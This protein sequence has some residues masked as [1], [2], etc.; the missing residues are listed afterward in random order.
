MAWITAI[1]GPAG[2]GKSTMFE[3]LIDTYK[4]YPNQ[5]FFARPQFPRSMSPGLGAWG[6]SYLDYMAIAAAIM[7]PENDYWVD[8][9]LISRTVYMAIQ[10]NN[11]QLFPDW[12]Q[13][14]HNS[15]TMLVTTAICDANYRIA[16]DFRDRP[17]VEIRV[18]VPSLKQLLVQR[19]QA[20]RTTGRSYAFRAET[21]RA[22]YLEVALGLQQEPIPG[23]AICIVE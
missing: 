23:I 8:R 2:S 19:E 7:M 13:R 10:D 18:L 11:S 17:K 15:Y 1:E 5:T 21:E 20:S 4:G 3:K 14:L 12:Y 16:L 6:S 22:L 9:F